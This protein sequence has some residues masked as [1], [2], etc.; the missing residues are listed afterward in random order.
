[1]NMHSQATLV[2]EIRRN[3]GC[4]KED[5]QTLALIEQALQI[6]QN[7]VNP[8][9]IWKIHPLTHQEDAVFIAGIPLKGQ[10]IRQHLRGCDAAAVMACT[11]SLSAE[12]TLRRLAAE[13]MA[14]ALVADA[15]AAALVEQLCDRTEQEIRERIPYRYMTARFSPGYGD[16]PLETQPVLLRLLDAARFLGITIT[17]QNILLPQKSVTA[18][19]GLSNQPVQDA[20]KGVC[21]VCCEGCPRYEDCPARHN[22]QTENRN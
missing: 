14:L 2:E 12:L 8:R 11:L 19:I 4:R 18:I 9:S 13:D 20:R 10:D 1:M 6:L 5:T 16:L 22:N 21:G 7:S 3:L 15:A 17:P